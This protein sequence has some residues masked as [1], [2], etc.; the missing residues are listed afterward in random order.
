MDCI[1]LRK[2]A[3]TKRISSELKSELKRYTDKKDIFD[4]HEHNK[5]SDNLAAIISSA[6]ALDLTLWQQKALFTFGRPY[7]QFQARDKLPIF[8]SSWMT[9]DLPEADE[10]ILMAERPKVKLLCVP[11]LHKVGTSEGDNYNDGVVICKAVV[12]CLIR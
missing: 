10:D 2:A 5:E 12:D 3:I 9:A 8:N 4:D 6:V 11:A 1:K 7:L